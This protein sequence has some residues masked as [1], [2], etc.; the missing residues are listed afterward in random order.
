MTTDEKNI[1]TDENNIFTEDDF[2]GDIDF[3]ELEEEEFPEEENEPSEAE[4]QYSEG[5]E[6]QAD[7]DETSAFSPGYEEAGEDEPEEEADEPDEP[8]GGEDEEN[9]T[10]AMVFRNSERVQHNKTVDYSALP[11]KEAQIEI[12]LREVHK[13]PPVQNAKQENSSGNNIKINRFCIVNTI[14]SAFTLC[15]VAAGIFAGY[16]YLKSLEED[17]SLKDE[18]IRELEKTNEELLGDYVEASAVKDADISGEER[19]IDI[20]KGKILLWDSILGY[21]WTPVLAGLPLNNYVQDNFSLNN[22][23]HMS[24]T[25]NGDTCSYFGIDVSSYQGDINWQLVREDGVEFAF[26]RIGF[27]GY[28]EEGNIRADDRFEANYE[29]AHNAGIDVGVYFYSQAISVEEA[30]EEAHFVLDKLNGRPLEYPIVFDWETVYTGSEEDVPRTED[31]MPH[32]LTLS[33]IAFCETIRDA[34]YEAMIYTNKR[35]A[36][37]KYDMRQL[38]NYP[39]W[40]AQYNTTLSYIY[41]FDIWQYG[42]GA[43]DG[44]EGD[45]DLNIAIIK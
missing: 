44:I 21:T 9:D 35:Q 29:G 17:I 3:E 1:F 18:R 10:V 45:V 37:L 24:Y 13:A 27:R 16:D 32:T 41:D 30:I 43:V 42:V 11:V 23:G 2:D 19:E 33:A 28:G 38:A 34:G 31:V 36:V 8:Y 4:A 22:R 26:L 12:P 20:E 5:E 40:L 25:V 6:E 7:T 14:I 15:A 39:V